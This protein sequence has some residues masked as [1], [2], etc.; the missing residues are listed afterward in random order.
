MVE[1]GAV[2]WGSVSSTPTE[3]RQRIGKTRGL[4]KEKSA[5]IQVLMKPFAMQ[6]AG[7]PAQSAC[8]RENI[9]SIA[10]FR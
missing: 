9:P 10:D 7:I 8:A 4:G 5:F 6:E 2:D 3:A 1:L